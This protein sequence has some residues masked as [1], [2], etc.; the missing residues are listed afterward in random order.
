[1][2]RPPLAT[3]LNTPGLAWLG[4]ALFVGLTAVATRPTPDQENQQPV[5]KKSATID[6][7][8]DTATAVVQQAQDTNGGHASREAVRFWAERSLAMLGHASVLIGLLMIG[9]RHFGDITTGVAAAALYTLLPYTAYNVGQYHSSAFPCLCGQS[10]P[11]SHPARKS[12]AALSISAASL[13]VVS[14]RDSPRSMIASSSTR[15]SSVS[16]GVIV[17]AVRFVVDSLRMVHWYPA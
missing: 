4:I 5:G 17:V 7:V 10:L 3:N 9:W 8:Q 13:R 1:M 16:N 6:Q 11:A 14:L 15:D 12:L 2:R